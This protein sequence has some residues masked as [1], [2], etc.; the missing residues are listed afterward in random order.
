LLFNFSLEYTI[1]KVQENKE[2]LEM[3][4]LHPLL[5]YADNVNLLGEKINII[6]KNTEAPLGAKRKLVW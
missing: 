4:G 6:Q 1:I 2:D 3:N 5:L